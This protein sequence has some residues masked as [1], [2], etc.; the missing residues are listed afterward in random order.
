[1]A[2]VRV[3]ITAGLLISG[4]PPISANAFVVVYGK[5]AKRIQ[6]SFLAPKRAHE[7][8]LIKEMVVPK[9][10][11]SCAVTATQGVFQQLLIVL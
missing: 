4:R 2:L 7:D 1:V 9:W 5:V 3:S 6:T 8:R 10:V 11:S